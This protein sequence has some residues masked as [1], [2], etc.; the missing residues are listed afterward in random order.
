[1]DI[2][3]KPKK[4]IIMHDKT[5]IESF[6]DVVEAVFTNRT[7]HKIGSKVVRLEEDGSYTLLAQNKRI[8]QNGRTVNRKVYKNN[9]LFA[10]GKPLLKENE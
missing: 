2:T 9:G 4:Y 7:K 8:L 6:D 1:M 3:E 10:N 5:I